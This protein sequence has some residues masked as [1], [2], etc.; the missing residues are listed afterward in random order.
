MAMIRQHIPN[1]VSGIGPVSFDFETIDELMSIEFVKQWK[2]NEF[3]QFSI[4]PSGDDYHLMCEFKNGT[5]WYVVGY[6]TGIKEHKLNLP[7][8][9][10]KKEDKMNNIV[11]KLRDLA[12]HAVFEPHTYHEAAD[13]IVLLWK[14]IQELKAERRAFTTENH[15]LWREVE[16]LRARIEALEGEIRETAEASHD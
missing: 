7:L 13:K 12:D 10:P 14:E 8:W 3:F 16:R 9:E 15:D 11:T 4:A 1:F 5:K 6:L 2:S